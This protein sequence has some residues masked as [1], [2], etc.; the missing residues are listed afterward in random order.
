M[1]A[2]EVMQKFFDTFSDSAV[3]KKFLK[4]ADDIVNYFDPNTADHIEGALKGKVD[5]LRN[6]ISKSMHPTL[7]KFIINNYRPLLAHF[8]LN[9]P[10]VQ[11][12]MKRWAQAAEEAMVDKDFRYHKTSIKIE[13]DESPLEIT[14][15]YN[16]PMNY[17][18]K[19]CNTMQK[20]C[21]DT[22]H[23]PINH[24]DN[25]SGFETEKQNLKNSLN[26]YQETEKLNM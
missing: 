5:M 21:Y 9:F 18:T 13:I 26:E 11:E 24:D 14:F 23:H 4:V 17:E 2:K 19:W 10:Y 22:E 12:Q 15:T 3:L 20:R 7:Q 16:T 1:G 8:G 25:L 6:K